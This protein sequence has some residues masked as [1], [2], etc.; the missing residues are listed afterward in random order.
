MSARPSRRSWYTP[1][2]KPEVSGK[3]A[4]PIAATVLSR[5]TPSGKPTRK[6][7]V[8]SA[9]PLMPLN[10]AVAAIMIHAG[11]MNQ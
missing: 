4:A 10:V 11:N 7:G 2:P 3:R 8:M 1:V 5:G 9:A 6:N